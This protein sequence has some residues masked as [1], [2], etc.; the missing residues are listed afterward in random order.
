MPK[1]NRTD[2]QR[3]LENTWKKE[4]CDRISILVDK[5]RKD[6]Y[7]QAAN[8]MGLNFK[9]FIV[10]SMDEYISSHGVK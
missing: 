2:R 6:Y 8:D 4:N 1:R 5:G 7:K 10:L 9:Q 3:E